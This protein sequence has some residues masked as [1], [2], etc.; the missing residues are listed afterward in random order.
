[1]KDLE[2]LWK[3]KEK[4]VTKFVKQP[5]TNTTVDYAFKECRYIIHDIG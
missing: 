1:M 3:E 2:N 5:V 4:K